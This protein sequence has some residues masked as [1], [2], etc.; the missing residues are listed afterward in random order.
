MGIR[1]VIHKRGSTKG[2]LTYE[3]AVREGLCFGWIDSKAGRLD[4]E[5]YTVWFAPRRPGSVW[6]ATNKRRIEELIAEGAMTEAGMAPVVAAKADGSWNALDRIEA[7]EVPD[8]LLAA[9]DRHAGSREN[10]DAFPPGARKQ[11]LA[12]IYGARRDETRARR[13]EQAASLA[14]R[15]ERANQPRPDR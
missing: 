3:E 2:T 6:S 4:D 9:F 15:N 7:L 1:L 8:D 13:V 11:I 5:R 10:W 12:W 14:S